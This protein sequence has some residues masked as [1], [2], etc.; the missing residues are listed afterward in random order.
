MYLFGTAGL[1]VKGIVS[2]GVLRTAEIQVLCVGVCASVCAST[3]NQLNAKLSVS[4]QWPDDSS[5]QAYHD[6]LLYVVCI[7]QPAVSIDVECVC[8]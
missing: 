1:T 5:K 4:G 8:V 2:Q 6:L 7:M 3:A